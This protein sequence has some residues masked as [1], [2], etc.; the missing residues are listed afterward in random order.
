MITYNLFEELP[1]PGQTPS[2]IECL[3]DAPGETSA[4]SLRM[5]LNLLSLIKHVEIFLYERHKQNLWYLDACLT[6]DLPGF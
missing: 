5:R 4:V 6:G 3:D 2:S 1:S